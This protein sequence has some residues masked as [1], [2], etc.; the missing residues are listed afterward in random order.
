MLAGLTLGVTMLVVVGGTAFFERTVPPDHQRIVGVALGDWDT[1]TRIPRRAL[2]CI[3]P[4]PA[5]LDETCT[6]TIDGSILTI[7]VEYRDGARF[8]RCEAT[9]GP[10]TTT[11]WPVWFTVTG[12]LIYASIPA[13]R[14]GQPHETVQWLGR[15]T[16]QR[17][18]IPHLEIAE[19]SLQMMRQQHPFA[20]YYERD[21]TT[22]IQRAALVAALLTATFVLLLSGRRPPGLAGPRSLAATV[23]S[24]AVAASCAGAVFG[25]SYVALIVQAMRAGLVD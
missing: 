3:Q 14:P 20:N 13:V 8:R 15:G 2:K 10:T 19:A 25:L 11:C 18:Q 7:G 23:R 4:D 9:Y 24:I 22:L 16:V 12:P 5:R 1:T 6:A 17:V 21:W